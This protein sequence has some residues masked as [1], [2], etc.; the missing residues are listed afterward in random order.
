MTTSGTYN[1]NL[2]KTQIIT[3]AFNELNVYNVGETVDFDDFMFASNK[4][5]MMFKTWE[6]E[7]GI[8]LWKRRLATLFP[9]LNQYSYQI[10]SVTGADK[11]T[12]SYQ[13][14]AVTQAVS[15]SSTSLVVDSVTG[16]SA[17]MQIGLELDDGT[18][19][20]GTISSIVGSTVN[21]D[22]S[23]NTTSAVGNTVIAYSS[24]INRP[25][26]ILRMNRVD[27]KNN[28]QEAIVAPISFDQYFNMPIK[29][30]TGYSTNFYYDRLINNS[31]PYTGTLYLFPSPSPISTVLT[32][33][34]SDC[35]QDMLNSNDTIDLPQEWIEPIIIGLAARLC[36]AYGK[37]AELQVLQPQS[38][39][40]KK[41]LQSSDNDNQPLH[42][43]PDFDNW[44]PNL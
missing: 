5:N 17:T 8:H 42:I 10:G 38:D 4:L 44:F 34:Y 41:I 7:D 23:T 31:L 2:N 9:A 32:F 11:C 20:W 24:P 1:F 15:I 36:M 40:L 3:M 30:M 18:R 29:S 33:S 26:D 43:M 21:V 19:Q 35:I 28:N 39:Q 25:L 6:V 22:F 27:L 12:N 16:L 14:T 37:L 13:S